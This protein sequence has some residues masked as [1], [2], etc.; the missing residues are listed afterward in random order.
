M[1]VFEILT[2]CK[3]L[4]RRLAK[5]FLTLFVPARD[6]IKMYFLLNHSKVHT[7][8]AIQPGT[9]P[10]RQASS[11]H[12]RNIRAGQIPGY[13]SPS[14]SSHFQQTPVWGL[15]EPEVSS[16]PLCF[17]A[18]GGASFIPEDVFT[19]I[20]ITSFSFYAIYIFIYLHQ[21]PFFQIKE[22]LSIQSLFIAM[23]F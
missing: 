18:V 6:V 3:R 22:S 4:W 13:P 9:M 1:H 21:L 5:L 20:S 8:R 7:E 19:Q 10:L 2:V 16:T 11:G 12:D 14:T 17:R 15:P 23:L